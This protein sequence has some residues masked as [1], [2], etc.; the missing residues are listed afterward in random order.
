MASSNYDGVLLGMSNPLLDISAVVSS[1]KSFSPKERSW[2][3]PTV[4]LVKE[5]SIEECVKE[6]G[7]YASNVVLQRFGCT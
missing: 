1:M 3:T 2:L 5:I 6:A 7:C 4:Q